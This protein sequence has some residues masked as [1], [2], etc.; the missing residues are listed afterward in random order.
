MSQIHRR[1][2]REIGTNSE[3]VRDK[4]F[5]ELLLAEIDLTSSQNPGS[6][7]RELIKLI[8]LALVKFNRYFAIK[9]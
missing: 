1:K 4:H 7:I 3:M 6:I 2:N 8:T 5:A 9:L